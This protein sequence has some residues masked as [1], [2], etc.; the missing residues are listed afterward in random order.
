MTSRERLLTT[1]NHKIADRVPWSALV[2][3]YFL[4]AQED[5]YKK[6]SPAGFLKEMGADLFDWVGLEAKSKG[7]VVKTYIDGKLYKTD[8]S[9]EWLTEF[10]DY[11]VD[12]DYYRNP[13]G[14]IVER[15][16]ITPL[17]ELTA[18]FIYTSTSHTVFIS[19]FPVKRLK[20]YRIFT[21]MI[22]SLEYQDLTESYQ[23]K[24]DEIGE[25]GLT[26]A[27][28]H[29]TPAYE[30]IQCFMG[31]ERFHYFL[32]DYKNETIKL[33]DTMFYKFLQCYKLYSNTSVPVM[34][35]G[36]DASTTIY[37]PEIFDNYLKPVLKEYCRIIKNA[38][39]I[40]VI[41]ACGHIKGLI[42][43]LGETGADCIESVSPPPTGNITVSEF[44]K[45]L[46]DFCVMGGIPANYYLLELDD[47]KSYV[48]NLL[49]ENKEG[50]NF[51]L[52]S[53]DSVPS[54]AKVDNIREIPDLVEKYGKY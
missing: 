39:K 46:P 14:R 22:E 48:M 37:S 47:F 8:S 30:L 16:F 35:V 4:E 24:E 5:K 53:G 15:K 10:Y 38:G 36:E 26:V 32:N 2:N 54:N 42:K 9:G 21:Y 17:G 1:L 50:G 18:K 29:C 25:D 28:L 52:S 31:M 6:M 20:D 23:K 41:H 11:L 43:S 19:E 44:K 34:L 51:I 12:I 33:M 13:K 7:V 40:A 45:A 3:N 27:F 49:L